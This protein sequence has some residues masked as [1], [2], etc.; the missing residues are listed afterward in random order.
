MVYFKKMMFP[1]IKKYIV[2]LNVENAFKFLN[3]IMKSIKVCNIA[4]VLC[5]HVLVKSMFSYIH[6]N[7]A[8]LIWFSSLLLKFECF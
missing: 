5:V 2:F 4:Y 1:L 3:L 7:D 6:P 8:K